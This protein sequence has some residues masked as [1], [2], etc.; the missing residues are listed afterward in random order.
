MTRPRCVF[1]GRPAIDL[2]AISLHHAATTATGEVRELGMIGR[3][4]CS[5]CIPDLK[6]MRIVIRDE[7]G[8]V[9]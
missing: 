4:A 3:H 2:R 5:A 8:E 6:K 1:C 7:N 9:I